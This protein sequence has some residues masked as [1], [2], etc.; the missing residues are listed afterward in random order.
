MTKFPEVNGQR[1]DV[2]SYQPFSLSDAVLHRLVQV[3]QL[4]MMTGTDVADHMRAVRLQ[5]RADEASVLELTPACDA[6]FKAGLE[7][8]QARADEIIRE[9]QGSASDVDSF[10]PERG[11]SLIIGC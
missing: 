5:P 2:A 10:V 9:A 4:A 8:L 11:T 7:Q 1:D 6:A 3:L